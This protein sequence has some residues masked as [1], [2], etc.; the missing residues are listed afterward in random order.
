M[1]QRRPRMDLGDAVSFDSVLTILTVLLVLRMVFLVPMVNLDKAKTDRARHAGIWDTTVARIASG[2]G[3]DQDA[4]YRDALELSGARTRIMTTSDGS[5]RWLEAVL[6]DSSI[7]VVRHD[8]AQGS[9]ARLHAQSRSE[10]P[11]CRF[12]RL[13]WSPAETR[14][15]SVSDSVDYG[16]SGVRDSILHAYRDWIAGRVP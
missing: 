3:E 9:F 14:W 8:L 1:A 4:S 12:G 6:P 7:V 15:F 11:G 5:A 2:G 13:R 16:N 10:L